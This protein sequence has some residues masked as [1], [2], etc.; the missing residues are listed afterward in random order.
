[1]RIAAVAIMI[2]VLCLCS[3]GAAAQQ[4]LPSDVAGAASGQ[5]DSK[6][7]SGGLA[8]TGLIS[9]ILVMLSAGLFGGYAG[10]LLGPS[11]PASETS[12]EELEWLRKRSMVAGVVASF[13]VPLFLSLA[14]AAS[15]AD[16]Q[17]VDR[18]V[19]SNIDYGAWLILLG[20]CLVAAVSAPNFISAVSDR[21]LRDVQREARE[22][23]AK[24]D[25]AR[26]EVEELENEIVNAAR[27]QFRPIS[28]DANSVLRGIYTSAE[29]RPS[30]DEISRVQS[31]LA[32]E[33]LESALEELEKQGLVR[34]KHY[35]NTKRWRV[36]TAGKA[37]LGTLQ[38]HSEQD[39]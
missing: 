18:L 31:D 9:I 37:Y 32:P 27:V 17:L 8:S 14:G 11:N 22:A 33:Q 35:D 2:L 26:Q 23:A 7:K 25:S 6:V 19:G 10:F 15:G 30:L 5:T 24:A 4:T 28:D 29:S 16:Q 34:S 12:A 3:F 13:T 1:M 36:R 38:A 39:G 21:I 20:F